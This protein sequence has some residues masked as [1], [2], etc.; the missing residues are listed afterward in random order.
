VNSAVLTGLSEGTAIALSAM[1]S[2]FFQ[3]VNSDLKVGSALVAASNGPPWARSL[4]SA[5]MV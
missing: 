4:P 2:S 1:L 3:L 5:G